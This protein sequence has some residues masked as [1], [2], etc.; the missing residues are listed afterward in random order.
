MTEDRYA[1]LKAVVERYRELT[2]VAASLRQYINNID[3]FAGAGEVTV[4]LFARTAAAILYQSNDQEEAN[5]V[6]ALFRRRAVEQLAKTEQALA[7]L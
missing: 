2:E 1:E 4:K 6:L 7:D 3:S 5:A